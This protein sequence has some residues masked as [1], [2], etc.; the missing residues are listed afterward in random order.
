MCIAIN[1]LNKL[2][3]E[4]IYVGSYQIHPF[5]S[6]CSRDK[7]GVVCTLSV[8]IWR[9]AMLWLDGIKWRMFLLL[10]G[11]LWG[12][13][14]HHYTWRIVWDT[15]YTSSLNAHLW[16]IRVLPLLCWHWNGS[17]VHCGKCLTGVLAAWY[18][19]QP[20]RQGYPNSPDKHISGIL[21]LRVWWLAC[22]PDNDYRSWLKT[23]CYLFFFYL[24]PTQREKLSGQAYSP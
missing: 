1:E 2:N 10:I 20:T 7:I 23:T 15:K 11:D 16:R 17:E 24:S 18:T 19:T 6:S 9:K 8:Q 21:Y 13:T 5:G 22:G 12:K 3:I 4:S 14:G